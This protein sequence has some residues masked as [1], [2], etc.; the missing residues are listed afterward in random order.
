MGS[1]YSGFQGGLK[2]SQRLT[3]CQVWQTRGGNK[4]CRKACRH[5]FLSTSYC[6]GCLWTPKFVTHAIAFYV[7]IVIILKC[8]RHRIHSGICLNL[9]TQNAW[10]WR[11]AGLGNL[12]QPSSQLPVEFFISGKTP[13]PRLASK[14]SPIH[15]QGSKP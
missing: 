15:T 8:L 3:I 2:G 14:N 9:A 12:S 7:S 1:I 6:V 10:A 4:C 5:L 13:M 11:P